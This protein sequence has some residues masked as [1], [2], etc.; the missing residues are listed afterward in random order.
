LHGLGGEGKSRLALEFI[1]RHQDEYHAIVWLS[2][3]DEVKV[4]QVLAEVAKQLEL[5]AE[6]S[7]DNLQAQRKVMKWLTGLGE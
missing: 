4:R 1:A 7:T 2:A 3:D 5:V 6:D